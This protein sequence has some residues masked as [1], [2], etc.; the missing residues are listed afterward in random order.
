MMQSAKNWAGSSAAADLNSTREGAHLVQRQV[1]SRFIVVANVIFQN[2]TQ[3]SLAQDN[4]V[5]R[6]LRRIDPISRSAKPL[7]RRPVAEGIAHGC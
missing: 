5:V 1:R 7:L 6:H 4:D 3:M 2:L